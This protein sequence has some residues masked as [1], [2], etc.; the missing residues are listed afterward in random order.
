MKKILILISNWANDIKK[1]EENSSIFKGKMNMN[2][3]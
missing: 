1:E 3:S 2:I